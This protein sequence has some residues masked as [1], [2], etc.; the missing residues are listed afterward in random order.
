MR[1]MIV[2][3]IVW[4]GLVAGAGLAR[5]GVVVGRDGKSYA[6]KV[7]FK[8][9]NRVAVAIAGG[10]TVVLPFASV[11]RL[12]M[13]DEPAAPP[14]AGASDGLPAPWRHADIGRVKTT[15]SVS[16][17]AGVFIVRG[18]GWGFWGPSDSG[19][20][21]LQPLCGDGEVIARL[22]DVPTEEDSF[23]A[24][25]TIRSGLEPSVAQVSVMLHPDGI[26]HLS[27]RP[28]HGPGKAAA[29]GK[30]SHWL[31]LIRAQD[32]FSAY[33]SADGHNWSPVGTVHVKMDEVAYAGLACAATANQDVVQ[34]KFDHVSVRAE[35]MGPIEGVGLVDGS[36]IA[37]KAKRF[38]AKSLT[39]VDPAN[40][41]H[42]IPV[43]TVSCVFT[44]PLLPEVR[45]KAMGGRPR[46]YMANGDVMEVEVKGLSDRRVSAVSVALGPQNLE[47]ARVAMVVL[48]P[49]TVS[50]SYSFY[51]RDG[52]V[53]RCRTV[54]AGEGGL[55]GV[56]AVAGRIDLNAADLVAIVAETTDR[57]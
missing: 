19:H 14:L 34:A 54:S 22:V 55:T 16:H 7:E 26:P 20:V 52:C 24:G 21:L 12:T 40:A 39:Y 3:V 51:T 10:E 37:G 8:A 50:G 17:S 44:R 42:T 23:Q 57:K 47:M 49:M 48:R 11:A 2:A 9:D 29:A 36:L 27:C 4:S 33:Y 32:A 53:Y 30:G 35:P 18:A 45:R 46:I 6:G 15:G 38:D 5:G 25:L 13:F 31:R 56:S 43:E 28:V 1:W 41:E